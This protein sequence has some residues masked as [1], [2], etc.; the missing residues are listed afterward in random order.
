MEDSL[1]KRIEP[2]VSV[3]VPVY[4]VEKY[5]QKCIDSLVNQTFKDIE[6]IL[7]DDGSKDGSDRICDKNCLQFPN[8]I[9]VIHQSNSGQGEA[10]NTGIRVARGK[11]LMFVD[12]DDYVRSDAVEIAYKTIVRM[13]TDMVAF[14]AHL[15]NDSGRIIK[16]FADGT[17]F[18]QKVNIWEDKKILLSSPSVWNKIYKTSLFSACDIWF[19]SRV[20]YEDMRTTLKVFAAIE[21]VVFIDDYLYFYVQHNDSITHNIN[22][23]RNKEILDAVDDILRYYMNR[24]IFE[25]FYDELEYI[26]ILNMYNATS[27]RVASIDPTNHL[28]SEFRT[29]LLRYFP[30]YRDNKYLDKF[31]VRQKVLFFLTEKR[32]YK[33]IKTLSL[34]RSKLDNRG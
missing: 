5:L 21:S 28:L 4:G 22:V 7:V 1:L 24:G 34:I 27:A 11:Y 3:V 16:S 9:K 30:N 10:R 20:W 6:I 17:V 13:N 23:E 12:G 25:E 29:Y 19:P 2:K 31:G 33:A 14:G 32:L 26:V 8:L 18:N 15:I